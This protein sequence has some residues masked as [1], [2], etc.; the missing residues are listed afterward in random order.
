MDNLGYTEKD[1]I[2]LRKAFEYALLIIDLYKFL[3]SEKKEFVLSKQLLRAGTS[4]GANTEE[5][6]EAESKAD[7]VHKFSISNKECRESYYWLRL[8]DQSGYLEDYQR[9]D[10]VFE[11]TIEL[12]RMLTSIITS[13]KR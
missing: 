12:K 7:F 1:N 13:S 8:L 11:R 3:I 4:V 10:E 5:A 9:K 6:Q 2:I